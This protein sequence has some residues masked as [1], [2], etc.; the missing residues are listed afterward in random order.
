M[1]TDGP[2]GGYCALLTS[3]GVDCW[4]VNGDGELGNGTY[5]N[6][7]LATPVVGVGGIGTLSGA[8]S[9]IGRGY[10]GGGTYS[11]TLT[12]GGVDC[13]GYGGGGVLGNGTSGG[14]TD[15]PTAVVGLGGVGTLTG[16]L[17][18]ATL[19]SGSGSPGF[20]AHARN[21]RGRLLGTQLPWRAWKRDHD[22]QRCANRRRG[23]GWG[24]D[25]QWGAEGFW[26]WR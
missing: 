3:G 7:D 12:S 13:W 26:R 9:L 6:S 4:G 15:V 17:S 10:G 18:L 19:T 23:P 20:C 22:Q 2:Q 14:D 1:A 24:R 5:T 25:T 21:R 11:A 16:V 8:T